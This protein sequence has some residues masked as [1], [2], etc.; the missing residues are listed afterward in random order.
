MPEEFLPLSAST[1]AAT[2]GSLRAGQLVEVR[3]AEEILATLDADG[4]IDGMPFMPEMLAFCGQTIRVSKRADKTCDTVMY[5]TGQRRLEGTV[6][7][8]AARCD[9]SAHGGCQAEC[10]LFWKES[11]LKPVDEDRPTGVPTSADR[12]ATIPSSRPADPLAQQLIQLTRRATASSPELDRYFC[13]ATELPGASRPLPW[14][15]PMQYVRDVRSQNVGPVELVLGLGRWFIVKVNAKILRRGTIP[16]VRGSLTRT[17]ADRLDLQPGERVRVKSKEEIERT[18][19]RNNRNRGLSFDSEFLPYCGREFVVRRRVERI[20]DEPTG[21]MLHLQSDCLIL[22]DVVCTAR[23][24]RFCPRQ[25]YPYWREVWLTRVPPT[26]DG[27]T[28]GP[29]AG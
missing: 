29:V 27:P 13:Q 26:P 12:A 28:A 19:D 24:H 4:R 5:A 9:G 8:E 15:D 10:L 16:S 20:I 22:D 7:L 6:H 25:I 18:L 2:P 17:P 11:W 23:Y 3:S 1:S 14:W 21:R